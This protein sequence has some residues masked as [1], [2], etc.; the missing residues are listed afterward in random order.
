MRELLR[1]V[2]LHL[3]AELHEPESA[4][5]PAPGEA[6]GAAPGGPTPA[7]A[8]A[9]SGGA[10]P[11]DAG[12]TVPPER[13]RN[14]GHPPLTATLPEVEEGP[15]AELA[16]ALGQRELRLVFESSQLVPGADLVAP[17]SHILRQVDELL[18]RRGTRAYV[19]R[20]AEHRLTLAAVKALIEPARGLRLG[21][22][23]RRADSG[24]DLWVVYRTRYHTRERT[25]AL[26]TLHVAL[27]PPAPPRV[28]PGE[29]PPG[30][31][32]WPAAPRKRA[33]EPHLGQGLAAADAAV[34]ERAREEAI[35]IGAEARRKL[36]RDAGRMEA[37]YAAQMA[38]LTRGTRRREGSELK[39]EELQEEQELRLRELA[40]AAEVRVE[41]EALQLLTVEVPLARARVVLRP[42]SASSASSSSA[43]ASSA[44]ASS[45][46]S[47][48]ASA[49]SASASSASSSSASASSASAEQDADGDAS[50]DADAP[51]PTPLPG[52]E[53][54]LDRSSGEL[55]LAPCQACEE[56][57]V[58]GKLAACAGL[59]ATHP[60]CLHPCGACR[61]DV[62]AACDP[63]PCATCQ[64]QLCP[65]CRF[66]CAHCHGPTCAEHQAA[67][68]VCSA[69]GCER[70][71]SACAHCG[72]R[73]CAQHRHAA[74]AGV[75][76]AFCVRCAQPCPGCETATPEPEQ[77]RCATCGR[78]F[79]RQ[80]HPP[81]AAACRLCAPP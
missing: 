35:R 15:A 42:A 3:G 77:V 12:L 7:T 57:V 74:A 8:P 60:A 75:E 27:R 48:S 70:C 21:L 17:G 22:A 9:A 47:S 67:C 78:R 11:G 72:E 18:A 52:L 66:T 79:C 40:A 19:E 2:L 63:T 71:F 50:A 59:H 41:V 4:P 76:A 32:A 55:I 51:A 10:T 38:E 14:G 25:D 29:P 68:A 58:G 81:E 44:S 54:V 24:W 73:V 34:A 28:E 56:S 49:S 37:Y 31:E 36:Q 33:P 6:A 69:S 13:R 20:P 39:L 62:C 23:D 43:S 64:R 46:S 26:E 53:V 61:R 65:A 1:E 80:C 45:A 16:R 5:A 30:F